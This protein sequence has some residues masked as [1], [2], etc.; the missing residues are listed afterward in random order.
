MKKILLV[1]DSIRIG[2][3]KYVQKAFADE[4]QVYYPDTNCRFAAYVL[5]H[6][7]DWKNATDCGDDV[8]V[9]YWNAGLWD[10][11]VVVD[12]QCQTPIEVY[13]YYIDRICKSIKILFPKAKMIFATSTT[14]I[15]AVDPKLRKRTNESTRQYNAAAAKI[16]ESH[17]GQVDD[18]FALTENIPESYH[19]DPTHYYTPEGTELLAGH[20]VETLENA[21]SVKG[22]QLDY[23]RLFT[24]AQN[25]IGE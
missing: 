9:V 7:P 17:G 20:V 19:S 14:V 8:D 1:G 6:L 24:E 22:R 21:L 10:N 5:R 25:V 15:E 11:L 13:E 12:G 2:Y 23:K 16:V 4:A 3:D 18:L